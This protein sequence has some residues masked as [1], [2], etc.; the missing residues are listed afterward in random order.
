MIP[1][2]RHDVQENDETRKSY[3]GGKTEESMISTVRHDVQENDETRK[4]YRRENR[5]INDSDGTRSTSRLE[6]GRGNKMEKKMSYENHL[7]CPSYL[8]MRRGS[9]R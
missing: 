9:P 3:R 6:D 2:V 7:P 8:Q 4:F 5:G 1:T